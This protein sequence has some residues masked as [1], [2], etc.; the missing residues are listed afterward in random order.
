MKR[1]VLKPGR[2]RRLTEEERTQ[3]WEFKL[4]V[5][6]DPCAKCGRYSSLVHESHHVISADYLRRNHLEH[7]YDARNALAVCEDCHAKHTSAM[8]RIP[9]RCLRPEN[10]QFAKELGLEHLLDRYYEEG[11]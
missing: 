4:A 9:R 2:P 5:M 6:G 8:E 1:S 10:E 7:V 3:A 11:S